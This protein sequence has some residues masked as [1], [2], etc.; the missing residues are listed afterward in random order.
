MIDKPKFY[1]KLR[2]TLFPNKITSLQVEGIEVILSEWEI[3]KLSD[4]RWLSYMLA[5][6]YHETA[7]TMQPIEEFGKGKGRTYGSKFKRSG[8]TYITPDKI[9]YGRG[10]VQLT[11][12]ENYELM[13]RLLGVD[14]LNNPESALVLPIATK[15]MYEGM[16]KGASSFGDFTGKCLEM[17]FNDKTDDPIGARRI[18][19]GQDRARDIASYHK[20]FNEALI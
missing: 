9:Y 2:L 1:N 10:F 20:L 11:W 17:Y 18:I 8:V 19:N 7:R 6:V 15:I 16:L 5:T 3:R 4:I 14:L 12:Y 13:G